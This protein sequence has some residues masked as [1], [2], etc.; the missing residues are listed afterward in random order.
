MLVI[1]G[2]PRLDNLLYYIF[3][4]YWLN[5]FKKCVCIPYNA[6][7]F[8]NSF[9]SSLLYRVNFRLS[10]LFPW[11]EDLYTS[12]ISLARL[13]NKSLGVMSWVSFFLLCCMLF[14][15]C[16]TLYKFGC[17]IS[18]RVGPKKLDFLPRINILP[19]ILF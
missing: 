12:Y 4:H 6:D 19:R 8:S 18:K 14:Q 10:L 13:S 5:R 17:G 7:S 15:L 16:W 1:S 3:C 11:L 9:L 2:R